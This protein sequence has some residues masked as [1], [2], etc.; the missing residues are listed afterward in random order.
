MGEF[1]NRIFSPIV[2]ISA[3]IFQVLSE[4]HSCQE[5]VAR[6]MA[7]LVAQGKPPCSPGTGGYC[8]ARQRL[9]NKLV[10]RLL[11]AVGNALHDQTPSHWQW[12]GRKV[13]LVDGT[14]ISMPDTPKN[15]AKYPQS[16]SQKK[17]VGFP[18]L[19]LVAAMSLATGAVIDL[20]IGPYQGKQTGEHA[21][22]RQILSGL[23][24]GDVLIGDRY[25]CSYFLIAALLA[26]GV[27][28]VFQNHASRKTD[29]SKGQHL[30]NE[31]HVIKWQKP[32]R[33]D[34]MDQQTY[35]NVPDTLKV[36]E[37]SV[38]G[39]VLISTFLDPCKKIREELDI[40]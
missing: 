18:V 3:F 25:Y 38:K 28:G 23:H 12:K 11:R 20:A 1:R 40:L 15:Q 6:V 32:I 26:M 22:L 24:S 36:R 17:G 16:E 27:D 19:R 34:W 7:E 33:P 30:G 14:T 29:F 31:D 4:D 8:Q 5:A 21:L 10:W 13:V 2:T 37:T 9:R 39:R 35:D